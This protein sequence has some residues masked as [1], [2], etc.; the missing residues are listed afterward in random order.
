MTRE[1]AAE[2]HRL[3]LKCSGA[4]DQ[5]IALVQRDADNDEFSSYR[6]AAA[7]LLVQ[8]MDEL[9]KPIYR[10]HPD[11]LPPELDREFLRD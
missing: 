1:T 9:M 5:S 7:H 6:L 10:Q 8:L 11:L 3:L 2:V 4:I